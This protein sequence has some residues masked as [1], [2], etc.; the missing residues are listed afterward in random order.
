[1]SDPGKMVDFFVSRRGIAADVAKEVAQ[2][3]EDRGYTV[4]V[5]DFDIA[6]STNFVGAIHDA[7]KVA[8]HFIGLLTEDYDTSPFTRAEWTSFFAT[9][10][11]SGDNR[12]FILLR[13]DNVEPP[14]LFAPIVYGNLFG[15]KDPER[16]REIIIAAA[17]GRST[18]KR[19]GS[20]VFHGV[21]PR[22][23]DFTGRDPLL[24]ELHQKLASIDRVS[25]IT[26]VAMHG[27][28]GI[29]KT[30]IATEYVY[31]HSADYAGV[32]WAPAE[33]SSNLITSLA[34]LARVLDPK[35]ASEPNSKKAAIAGLGKL[36]ESVRPWLVIYDNVESP[37]T[38]RGLRPN[39]GARLLITTR[40]PDWRGHAA[41]I[42]V[43]VFEP[44]VA[45][46]FLL[47]RSGR[48]DRQGAARLAVALGYLP[49][50][51]DHAGAYVKLTGTSF[52]RYSRRLQQLIR[53]V[54]EGAS[55]PASVAATVWLALEKASEKCPNAE[56]LLAVLSVLS[57][58]RISLDL[59]DDSL[60]TESEREDALMALYSVSLIKYDRSSQTEPA[61]FVHRLVQ[62]AMRA[63]LSE[64]PN[65]S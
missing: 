9:A 47:R 4:I 10:A 58:D 16:R 17:E 61:F 29:G 30:S 7:L 27:L 11:S 32:W 59:V 3:L 63:R 50:A 60:M 21:P 35:L 42:E 37:E 53:K 64:N 2:V 62:A 1:M 49:L 22:N 52:D 55:Y 20:Q 6:F 40:F 45:M 41:E 8:K 28:P 31:R 38:I 65:G 57:P 19:R 46:E 44:E 14:G 12:R 54:P 18:G 23:P 33:T 51:L 26:Q 43:E 36:A 56:P 5:Q 24:D 34:E 39:T 15:V 48:P 13:V 25:G